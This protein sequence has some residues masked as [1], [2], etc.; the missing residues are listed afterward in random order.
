M[1]KSNRLQLIKAAYRARCNNVPGVINLSRAEFK[2]A[3]KEVRRRVEDDLVE[4]EERAPAGVTDIVFDRAEHVIH[5]S[6]AFLSP[7]ERRQLRHEIALLRR[8]KTMI[9]ALPLCLPAPADCISQVH[10][11]VATR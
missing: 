6:D 9:R 10:L 3:A 2:A 7:K 5:E 8:F 4:E 11:S 1:T